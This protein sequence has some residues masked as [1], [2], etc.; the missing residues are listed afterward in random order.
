MK[1]YQK[2]EIW[3]IPILSREVVCAS[4]ESGTVEDKYDWIN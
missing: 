4:V 3:I 2:P 1:S